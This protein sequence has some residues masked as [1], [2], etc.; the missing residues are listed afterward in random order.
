M[1]KAI[2]ILCT[3]V[4]LTACGGESEIENQ[5]TGLH[6]ETADNNA[7]IV[8][9]YEMLQLGGYIFTYRNYDVFLGS[10]ADELLEAL[11]EPTDIFAAE[12]CAFLGMDYIY[13]YPGVHFTTFSPDGEVDYILTVTFNDDSVETAE[14]AYIGMSMEQIM[15]IYGEPS[16]TNAARTSYIKDGM[17]LNFIFDEGVLIDITYYYDNAITD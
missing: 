10:R 4:L 16:E 6:D 5:A 7:Y 14:G 12:S 3:A 17:S 13:Y 15:S 2:L 9:T 11:G 8:S 1:K